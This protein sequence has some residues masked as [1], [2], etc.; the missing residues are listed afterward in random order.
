MLEPAA[1]STR[2]L[3]S[4]GIEPHDVRPMVL[5]TMVPDG[6]PVPD[7]PSKVTAGGVRRLLHRVLGRSGQ[8]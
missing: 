4:L 7:W 6:R 8:P 2:V 3:A 1:A 5:A